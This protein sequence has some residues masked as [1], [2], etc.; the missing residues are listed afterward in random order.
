MKKNTI[1][2]IF[3]SSGGTGGHIIPARTLANEL[4]K[5]GF[6]VKFLGDYKISN[7]IK[8]DDVFSSKIISSSPIKKSPSF[9]LKAMLKI[10]FGIFQSLFLIIRYRPKIVFSFGG[11]AT[12]PILVAAIIT[13]RKII[14]HEQNS[15]LGKVNRI[16]AKFAT[17]IATSFPQT[18]GINSEF[19]NKITLTGNLV[20][21]EIIEIGT[22]PFLMPNLDVPLAFDEN[23]RMGYNVLLASD[24]KETEIKKDFFRIL[25]IGGSGGAEIFSEILPKTFFNLSDSIKDKIQIIQQCRESLVESTYLQYCSYNINIVVDKFFENMSEL[26][27]KSHLIIARAG[28]SSIFEFCAAKRPMILV[29]FAKSA[30]NHQAKNAAFLEERNAAIVINEKDFVISKTTEILRNLIMNEKKLN[31]L[32]NNAHQIFQEDALKK[33]I[34][35]IDDK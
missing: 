27:E 7:Y 6:N 16:F 23:L 32:A 34:S 10:S 15:H 4:Y 25:I 17:K 33:L 18:S 2:R 24:F 11:Y 35:L 28:S 19:L 1:V 20:R 9:L 14:L 3:I 30:D 13:N 12:F 31:Y 5:K 26:I 29:P 8:K 21:P 22:K